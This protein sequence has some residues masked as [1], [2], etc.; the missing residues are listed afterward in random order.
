MV[1][2][3]LVLHPLVVTNTIEEAVEELG[4]FYREHTEEY[5][6]RVKV[7]ILVITTRKSL[8]Q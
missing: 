1:D 5:S 7:P 4:K 8:C 2:L 6:S 3:P